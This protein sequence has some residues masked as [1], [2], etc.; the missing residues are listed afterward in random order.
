MKTLILSACVALGATLAMAA[1]ADTVSADT[2]AVGTYVKDS[3]ITTKVKAQ[4]AAKHMSTLAKI[5]VDTDKNGVVW[6]SG[7]AP[8]KDAKDLAGM[9]TKD[10]GGVTAVHNNIVVE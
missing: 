8:T 2:A 1:V 6:L 5:S 3:A 10:T 7:A 4:L 9:I